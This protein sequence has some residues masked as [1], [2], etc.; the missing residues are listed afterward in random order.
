MWPAVYDMQLISFLFLNSFLEIPQV[1]LLTKVDKVCQ[2]VEEDVTLTFCSEAIR[3]LVDK[4]SDM[5]GVPRSHVLPVKNFEK[6]IDV[7]TDVSIL[8]LIALRQILR[9]SEDFLFNFI[10]DKKK[11][12]ERLEKIAD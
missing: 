10:N 3:N 5:F 6:E 8:A 12:L 7:R 2:Y 9:S 11:D 1:I 4:F